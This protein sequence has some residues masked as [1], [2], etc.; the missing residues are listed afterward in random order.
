MK[1]NLE[2]MLDEV[3]TQM[4]FEKNTIIN[5]NNIIP[6]RPGDGISPLQYKNNWKKKLKEIS[7]TII[8]FL[9]KDLK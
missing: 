5:E 7:M 6:K 4:V 9:F 8:K 3:F 2:K 1:L